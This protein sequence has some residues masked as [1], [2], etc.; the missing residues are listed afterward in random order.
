MKVNMNKDTIIGTMK[1]LCLRK[2]EKYMRKI[3]KVFY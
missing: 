2:F 3:D 1:T